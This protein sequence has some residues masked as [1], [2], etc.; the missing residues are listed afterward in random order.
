MKVTGNTQIFGLLGHPVRHSL[1]PEMH[2]HLFQRYHIDAIYLAF[3]VS[4]KRAPQLAESIR[5]LG[6]RG[7]NLTV[8]FKSAIL[9]DLDEIT[10]AGLEAQAVN[11]VI[12]HDHTLVGY[13][14]DGEG[15]VQSLE[16]SYPGSSQAHTV[17]ILGAG[18]A[19]CAIAASLADLGA[20]DIHFLNRSKTR[21]RRACDHL[22]NYFPKTQFSAHPLTNDQ[23]ES[24]SPNSDL[25]INC[26][27]AGANGTIEHLPIHRLPEEA[28][29]CDINYWM[30]EPPALGRCQTVGLR[31]LTGLGMLIHQGLLS[32]ELFTGYPVEP[33]TVYALL[34][35]DKPS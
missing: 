10:Q 17:T 20:T 15:F 8:P 3:D 28:I 12:Q 11:V 21:A 33:E 9:E 35:H 32:F 31:T 30:D 18:G 27:A 5:T 29:W 7:V 23:F 34:N 14:T 24:V 2:T 1:S 19:A 6:I 26:T 4:P 22:S 13:N 25:I 16:R